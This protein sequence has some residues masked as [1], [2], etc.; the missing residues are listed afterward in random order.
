MYKF[1]K[2][3]LKYKLDDEYMTP[4]YAFNGLFEY[5]QLDKSTKIWEPFFGDGGSVQKIQKIGYEQVHAENVNFFECTPPDKDTMIVTNPPFSIKKQVL[6]HIINV[7]KWPRFALLLPVCVL[8]TRYFHDILAKRGDIEIEI[9]VPYSR[10]QFLKNGKA[11]GKC[12]FDSCWIVSGVQLG[13]TKKGYHFLPPWTT[14]E[15]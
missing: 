11:P 9:L 15:L 6:D 7:L 2:H 4:L 8:F 10:I 3:S 12:S 1:P 5:I 14:K 13:E